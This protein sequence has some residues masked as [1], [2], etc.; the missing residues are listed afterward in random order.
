[1]GEALKK[2]GGNADNKDGVAAAMR[3]VTFDSPK[4]PFKFDEKQQAIVTVIIR[5][6]ENQAGTMR[7]VVIDQIP[8][9]DQ[10]W[11]APS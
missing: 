1:M 7:N 11:K 3:S 4:G 8:N 9:V 2:V 6:V 5:K 10:F